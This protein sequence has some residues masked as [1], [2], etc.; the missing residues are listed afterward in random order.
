M[1]RVLRQ[2]NFAL[3]WI[4]GLISILG[5]WML[6]VGLPIYVYSLTGST[7]ATGI[8]FVLETLPPVFLSSVAG[9]FV[10]RWNRKWVL[11]IADLVRMVALLSLLLLDSADQIWIAYIVSAVMSIANLFANPAIGA[12][13]PSLVSKSDLIV[14]N[15]LNSLSNN[16]ARLIGPALG[17][18]LIAWIGFQTVV[19]IDSVS[20]LVSAVLTMLITVRTITPEQAEAAQNE[21][22]SWT[23][24][25]REWIDGLSLVRN[26]YVIAVIFLVIG[27]MMLAEGILQVLFVI[28]INQQLNAGAQAFGLILSAQAI[29]G[30]IGSLMLSRIDQYLS[31]YR[32]IGFSAILNGLLL[33]VIFNFPSLPLALALFALAGFPIIGFFVSIQ[34]LLQTN[35]HDDYRG[36]ILGSYG[37]TIA[38]TTLIGTMIASG[39]GDALGSAVMLN[40]VGLLNIAAGALALLC[41]RSSPVNPIVTHETEPT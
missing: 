32:L 19:V 28:F 10:D 33:L 15:S 2:R 14:A 1:F 12:L 25:W 5:D 39:L 20:F 26:E 40:A 23:A 9:V 16:L 24:V 13:L 30:I 7:L 21:R 41:F 35:T 11:I 29:G 34:T 36:R 27:V 3:F 37:T 38:I 31:L 8:T 18:S 4:S 6:I 17:G 22:V